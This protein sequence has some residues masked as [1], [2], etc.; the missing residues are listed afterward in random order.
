MELSQSQNESNAVQR[1]KDTREVQG[2]CHQLL[3]CL[4]LCF[5]LPAVLY[6]VLRYFSSIFQNPF[7]ID[8]SGDW[9]KPLVSLSHPIRSWTSRCDLCAC[10]SPLLAGYF[11][12]ISEDKSYG[13]EISLEILKQFAEKSV[14]K[15]LASVF[16]A[17]KNVCE[18]LCVCVHV[19]F[20]GFCKTALFI[21]TTWK[22]MWKKFVFVEENPRDVK[23]NGW[24]GSTSSCSAGRCVYRFTLYFETVLCYGR[25]V[26][27]TQLIIFWILP[28][29]SGGHSRSIIQL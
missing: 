9:L 29:F 2:K 27:R 17:S 6:F 11:I 5:W 4:A 22:T 26:N 20:A 19:A 28:V 13:S 14:A 3:L 25:Y 21:L 10:V 7:A 24:N 12:W 18:Y 1:N 16:R 23:A 8:L 15:A